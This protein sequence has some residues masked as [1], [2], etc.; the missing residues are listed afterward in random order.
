MNYLIEIIGEEI[1]TGIKAEVL[2]GE[3]EKVIRPKQLNELI[4]GNFNFWYYDKHQN[5]LEFRLSGFPINSLKNTSEFRRRLNKLLNSQVDT[6]NDEYPRITQN[7]IDTHGRRQV[8]FE[9]RNNGMIE[10]L[11]YK[12]HLS[13]LRFKN[14]DLHE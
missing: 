11:E 9:A 10:Y 2:I 14:F 8:L 12:N 1:L 4:L 5:I 3:N 7:F 13:Y 6:S